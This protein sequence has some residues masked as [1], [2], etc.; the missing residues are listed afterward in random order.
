MDYSSDIATVLARIYSQP[1]ILIVFLIMTKMR[2]YF[3][4]QFNSDFSIRLKIINLV[5]LLMVTTVVDGAFLL[6][7]GSVTPGAEII[8]DYFQN[9]QD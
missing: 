8:F 7:F 1:L 5:V 3:T 2:D 4:F 9:R 6:A